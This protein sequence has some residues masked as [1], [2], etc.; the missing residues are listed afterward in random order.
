MTHRQ[1][2]HFS[3][4]VSEHQP[5]QSQTV[6]EQDS[7]RTRQQEQP[8]E[9]MV[10]LP[11]F[12]PG[13]RYR[14][15]DLHERFGGQRQGGISTPGKWN[16][17]LLFTGKSGTK[18]GY[19]DHWSDEGVFFY[20]GEG[21]HGDPDVIAAWEDDIERDVEELR[22]P[23]EVGPVMA[24]RAQKEAELKAPG[25]L[26]GQQLAHH[27]FTAASRGLGEPEWVERVMERFPHSPR[28]PGPLR[29]AYE[30][31]IALLRR[32]GPWPWP[33]GE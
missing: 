20:T 22:D 18:H 30:R 31:T 17:L 3:E 8:L 29:E 32:E 11:Q 25:G 28:Q 33:R 2:H 4:G 15:R 12:V 21:Q 13:Q 26:L 9:A 19:S 1:M 23:G 24:L 16:F 5:S 14:R 27:A 7:K 6:R 10:E